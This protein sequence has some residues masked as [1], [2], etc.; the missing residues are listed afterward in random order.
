MTNSNIEK[1]QIISLKTL[2][3]L[4]NE[5]YSSKVNCDIKCE[6]F[7]LPKETLEEHMYTFLSKKYGLKNLVIEW[8]K[9]IISGIKYYSKLD[10]TVLLFGKI[11][12]NEQEENA[13]FIIQSVSENI[14][15]LL[16]LYIKERNPLKL[17][18]DINKIFLEKKN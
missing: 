4:I 16:L 1:H 6:Q 8:A 2:K 10:S 17:F 13:R 7:K 11:M 12:R 15:A 9:N 18:N 5:L 3:D 14:E